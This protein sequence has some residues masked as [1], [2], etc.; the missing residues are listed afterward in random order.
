MN[1]LRSILLR[2]TAIALLMAPPTAPE[3]IY[4]LAADGFRPPAV[5]L[6][7]IDPYFSI[8]STASRLTND[9]T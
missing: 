3:E 5:P 6:V 7:P 1:A 2:S 4:P 8:W 9:V